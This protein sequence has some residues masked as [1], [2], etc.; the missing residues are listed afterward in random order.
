[1]TV[2]LAADRSA[3]FSVDAEE[4]LYSVYASLWHRRLNN[5][6]LVRPP[7]LREYAAA[8]VPAAVLVAYLV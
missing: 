1:M 2:I 4:G 8:R 5:S 6:L 3:A 7:V